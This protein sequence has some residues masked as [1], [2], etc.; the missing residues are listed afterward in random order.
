MK[1]YIAIFTSI[2]VTMVSVFTAP[3]GTVAE[4]STGVMTAEF[5]TDDGKYETYEVPYTITINDNGNVKFESNKFNTTEHGSLPKFEISVSSEKE[6][7]YNSNNYRNNNLVV[8]GVLGWSGD[9]YNYYYS[10]GIHPNVDPY[11]DSQ[12]NTFYLKNNE[13]VYFTDTVIVEFNGI[14]ITKEIGNG[15]SSQITTQD[16]IF[17]DIDGDGLINANDAFLILSYSA[18]RGAGGNRSFKEWLA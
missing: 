18:Y 9:S 10:G 1:K 4:D 8:Y 2:L 11:T 12:G 13:K 14:T 16:F 5:Y 15:D 6:I 17:G 7:L 3:T